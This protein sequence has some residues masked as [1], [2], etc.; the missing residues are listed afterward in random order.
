VPARAPARLPGIRFEAPPPPRFDL[1]RMD[2]A[3]FVGFAQ[4]G[5]V[6]RPVMVE[7]FDGFANVFGGRVSLA[8]DDD[9]GESIDAHLGP[10]VDA[11]F[12][13]GGRRCWVVRVAGQSASANRFKLRGLSELGTASALLPVHTQARSVGSWSDDLQ[14]GTVLAAQTVHIE[15]GWRTAKCAL[16]LVVEAP[17][18]I[19]RGDL[20]RLTF[21][22]EAVVL[23][24]VVDAVEPAGADDWPAPDWAAESPVGVS[25]TDEDKTV[26]LARGQ[27]LWLR[28]RPPSGGGVSGVF[29]SPVGSPIGSPVSS[30]I[31]SPLDAAG[32]LLANQT[33]LE[34]IPAVAKP[35]FGPL[36]R[37]ER[38][39][40]EVH[41]RDVDGTRFRLP[42]LGFAPGHP[43]HWRELPTDDVIYSMTDRFGV[44][45]PLPDRS[46]WPEVLTPRFPLCGTAGGVSLPIALDDDARLVFMPSVLDQTAMLGREIGV[47]PA[48]PLQ[49]DGLQRM[50][51][52]LF[53]DP[54]LADAGLNTV[55]SEANFLRYETS[56]SKRHLRGIHAALEADEATLIVVPDAVQPAW[57]P[58]SPTTLAAP[59]PAPVAEPAPDACDPPLSALAGQGE[60]ED[61]SRLLPPVLLAID[62]AGGRSYE[63]RWAALSAA[64]VRYVLEESIADDFSDATVVYSGTKTSYE[65]HAQ[66]DGAYF[67]RVRA[68][69]EV[70]AH[71]E[72]S[73]YSV[74]RGVRVRARRA[75]VVA[76]VEAYRPEAVLLPI[77]RALL[78]LCAAHGELFAVLGLPRHY[79]ESAALDHAKSLARL[80]GND[81]TLSFGALYH[82]WLIGRHA[83]QS[84]LRALPPDGA[85]CGQI[86]ARTLDRGPW[87]APANNPFTSVVALTPSLAESRRLELQTANVNVVRREPRGFLLLSANTLSNDPEL[88]PINVRRLLSF[89]RRVAQRHGSTYVFEPNDATFQRSIQ[90]GFEGLLDDM[91]VR[92]AFAGDTPR[93]AYR[94]DTG[95]TVNTP[96]SMDAGRFI[97]ELRVA[98]AQ[99]L[100]F[101]T[102]RLVQSGQQAL[103]VVETNR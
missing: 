62:N 19:A 89:L 61:S 59:E 54:G 21:P 55:L 97:V 60:F 48:T 47:D 86:A 9:R 101:L 45:A 85:A 71:L 96:Q 88:R 77:H 75:A 44:L 73:P 4:S 67:Y 87:I 29:E 24:F 36:V 57:T 76:S 23:L 15:Q 7:D 31:G 81:R 93:D 8:W 42:G 1:P 53:L 64:N 40:F 22:S 17:P 92:G 82:P 78:T 68:E 74:G 26:L 83:G 69:A 37:V 27:E 18:E 41:V 46:T 84:D 38:L 6:D 102:I 58:E 52:K 91:F 5:P 30:P 34:L 25:P 90:R 94:V 33:E 43:R 72:R 11:F 70:G 50:D 79:R 100:T 28:S 98:P 103:T 10:A 49:R 99:P 2:V 3:L 16:R 35:T 39:T 65:A 32:D 56:G 20:V 51:A 63:V 80:I 12:R 13:N 66:R 14:V 95:Q